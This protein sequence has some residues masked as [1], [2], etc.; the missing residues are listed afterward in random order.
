MRKL[1]TCLILFSWALCAAIMFVASTGSQSTGTCNGYATS[2]TCTYNVQNAGSLLVVGVAMN[3]ATAVTA[4]MVTDNDSGGSTTY[5]QIGTEALNGATRSSLFWGSPAHTGN[6]VITVNPAA[7][8]YITIIPMEVTGA[9]VTSPVHA[10]AN[11]T[12]IGTPSPL[13]CG[14]VAANAGELVVGM[15]TYNVSG[16]AGF[17]NSGSWTLAGYLNSG[18]TN[19]AGALTYQIVPSATNYAPLIETSWNGAAAPC[20]D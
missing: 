10:T 7:T 17:A 16:A 18:A 2:V 13:T 14:T 1:L 11:T 19:E 20:I 9:S 5:S 3:G 8:N 12:G 15:A 6:H 4:A